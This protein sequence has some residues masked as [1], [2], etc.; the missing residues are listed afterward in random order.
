MSADKHEAFTKWAKENGISINGV[1]PTSLPGKGLG[2][3]ATR[4]LKKGEVVASMP[5][6]ALITYD[7]AFVR[8]A[9]ISSRVSVYGAVAAALTLRREDEGRWW[10]FWEA[11]WPSRADFEDSMPLCWTEDEQVLL[12]PAAQQ[13]L[14]RQ[15]A[16][17]ERDLSMLRDC[18]PSA[19]E[20]S[21]FRHYWLI[22]NTRCFFWE[23]FSKVRELRRRGKKL[24]RDECLALVPWGDYFNHADVGCTVIESPRGASITTDRAYK[25][26]E[27]VVVSYGAHTNDYLLVEYG[28]TLPHG[29]NK[30]DSMPITEHISYL[31]TASQRTLLE[32][33][34]YMGDYHMGSAGFC[35]RAQIALLATIMSSTRF[36][37]FMAASD[38]TPMEN[39][40]LRKRLSQVCSSIR[41]E[42]Q[43]GIEGCGKHAGGNA[44]QVIRARWTQMMDMLKDAE[45]AGFQ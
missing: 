34:G 32:A 21:W 40:K 41:A 29:R 24:P 37:A 15:E 12:P 26:G 14:Q 7:S 3:T 5:S 38:T 31:L 43:A 23:Y 35:Y 33:H 10:R 39:E 30:W 6:S 18:L 16:K 22:V 42:I 13:L 2:I 17:Y 36:T 11:T 25:R 28:F 19:D 4:D 45:V 44:T 27:E 1:T 20:E 9:G 8:E